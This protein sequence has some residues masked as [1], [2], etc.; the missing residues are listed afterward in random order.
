MSLIETR[1]SHD[2]NL[3][4]FYKNIVM[5]EHYLNRDNSIGMSNSNNQ[6][7]LCRVY[8]KHIIPDNMKYQRIEKE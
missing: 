2:M 8:P 7:N 5:T 3:V 6:K 1:A 4:E